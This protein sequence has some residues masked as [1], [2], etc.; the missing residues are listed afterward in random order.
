MSTAFHRQTDGLT[1]KVNSI[2]ERYLHSFAAGKERS[3]AKLLPLAEFGYNASQH[4][5]TKKTPF[6]AD[7][8]Y[9]PPMP[10]AIIATTTSATQLCKEGSKR[11][12]SRPPW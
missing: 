5:A 7:L 6:E 1:E 11:S 4:K 10:L 3:W 9:V 8:G 2:I 12:T